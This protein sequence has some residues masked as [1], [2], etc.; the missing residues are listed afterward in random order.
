MIITMKNKQLTRPRISEA[1]FREALRYF[2]DDLTAQ[3]ISQLSYLFALKEC[4]LRFNHRGEG[5][6]LLLSILRQRPL[7][8][9]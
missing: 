3:Q 7:K 9:S 1:K 4:E 8:S 5:L 6:Y 2:T